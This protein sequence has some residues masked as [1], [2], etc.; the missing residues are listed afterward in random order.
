GEPA[1]GNYTIRFAIVGIEYPTNASLIIY[2][3]EMTDL[4]LAEQINTWIILSSSILIELWTTITAFVLAG[5][6]II[7]LVGFAAYI[8]HGNQFT[9]I[10]GALAAS[11]LSAI[12]ITISI[13]EYLYR[14]T[15]DQAGLL[16]WQLLVVHYHETGK[17]IGCLGE[18][19]WGLWAFN[20]P[21]F[22]AII[23][24]VLHEGLKDVAT[25]SVGLIVL[26]PMYRNVLM[27]YFACYPNDIAKIRFVYLGYYG[28]F[29]DIGMFSIVEFGVA[30]EPPSP[31]QYHM[32]PSFTLSFFSMF[33]LL[34][35]TDGVNDYTIFY[36]LGQTS[37]E[38]PWSVAASFALAVASFE[39]PFH[40]IGLWA[41]YGVF[42]GAMIALFIG[43]FAI[44]PKFQNW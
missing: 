13:S 28:S 5:A 32:I 44:S 25:D 11:I 31:I 21:A 39:G 3:P 23:F 7:G 35:I 38:I 33:F 29:Q 17:V 41:A 20:N 12:A 26:G 14:N 34:S 36:V 43:M 27:A 1:P 40:A 18:P 4:S 6:G 22:T 8:E 2:M 15:Y 19:L 10:P 24:Y 30:V 16:L 37:H 9:G 42:I